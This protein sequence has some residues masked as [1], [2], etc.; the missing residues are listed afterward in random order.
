[1]IYLNLLWEF[2]QIGLFTIGGGY[3]ALPLIKNRIVDINGYISL[4]EFMDIIAIADPLLVHSHQ[5]GDFVGVKTA[6]ILG[7]LISTI[8]FVL[9][10]LTIVLILSLLYGKYKELSVIKTTLKTI[11]PVTLGLI[12]VAAATII[13]LAFLG[14]QI[15]RIDH[16]D[17]VAIGLFAVS[18]SALRAFKLNPI[19][20]M[21]GCGGAGLLLYWII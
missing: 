5:R 14:G 17:Y 18:L 7:G 1:M 10:S 15:A 19:W 2:I 11:R 8:G 9:P 13:K 21:L 16:I 12:A 6:G 4:A 3:A 20:I